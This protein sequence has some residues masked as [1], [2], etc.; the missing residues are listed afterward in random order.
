MKKK[1]WM[2]VL[3]GV[4]LLAGCGEKEQ[5]VASSEGAA[6]KEIVSEEEST[7]KEND[8]DNRDVPSEKGE[9]DEEEETVATEE[10]AD[11]SKPATI[12]FSILK[13]GEHVQVAELSLPY[14]MLLLTYTYMGTDQLASS[15][16]SYG[17]V[18]DFARDGLANVEVPPSGYTLSGTSATSILIW[19]YPKA[20]MSDYLLT[21]LTINDQEG[22]NIQE[23][24]G[25]ENGNSYQFI[26]APKGDEYNFLFTC[27]LKDDVEFSYE[28][29]GGKEAD[30]NPEAKAKEIAAG[31]TVS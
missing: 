13:D 10:A 31:L 1:I 6:P 20:E 15:S 11:P 27:T 26:H 4:F 28:I 23:G 7:D 29:R 22:R 18:G 2:L 9:Q 8:S 16:S 3:A 5:D 25:E 21:H 19:A 12:P 24:E 14:D 30:F 17:M